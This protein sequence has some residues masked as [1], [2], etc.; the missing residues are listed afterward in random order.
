MGVVVVPRLPTSSII[1]LAGGAKKKV[2]GTFLLLYDNCP[3]FL[4]GNSWRTASLVQVVQPTPRAC[5]VLL[6]CKIK[7]LTSCQ[8]P[9]SEQGIDESHP[10]SLV[11]FLFTQYGTIQEN[12]SYPAAA[13]AWH[14]LSQAQAA[15]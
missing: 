9:F 6:G 4:G 1:N 14:L 3:P 8:G 7:Y 12:Q 15:R 13:I 11:L 10:K 5:R 2:L